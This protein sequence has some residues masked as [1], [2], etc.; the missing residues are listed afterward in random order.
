MLHKFVA[1]LI[2]A[3]AVSVALVAAADA[4]ERVRLRGTI[5]S[6]EG[7]TLTMTTREGKQVSIELTDDTSI[8]GMVGLELSDIGEGDYIGAAALPGE[9]DQLTA[10]EVHLFPPDSTATPG[11]GP[12]DLE[13]GSTMTNAIVAQVESVEGGQSLT[14]TYEGGSQQ[15]LVNPE[16]PVV[17]W[18]QS[19]ESVLVPGAAVLVFA[20]RQ[21]DGTHEA[22]S[23]RAEKDGVRPPM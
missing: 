19:D 16:T 4:Q 18:E 12:F 21:E 23:I 9:G 2:G 22:V 15:I 13:P 5:D 1:P 8:A 20:D 3:F 11:H 6:L 7:D 14:V 17:T 10:L